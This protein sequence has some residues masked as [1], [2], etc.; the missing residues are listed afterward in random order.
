MPGSRCWTCPARPPRR[1][2][3]VVAHGDVE[4]ANGVRRAI[5][6]WLRFMELRP[7]GS[8]AEL[9]RYI[10]YWEPYAASHGAL[11][12]DEAVQEEVR[13]AARTLLA[14]VAAWRSGHLA[15]PGGNLRPARNK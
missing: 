15:P 9:D 11:D 8:M 4:G 2:F 14:A 1:L 13:N 6:D 7:A 12:K 5:S 10:G 3:A